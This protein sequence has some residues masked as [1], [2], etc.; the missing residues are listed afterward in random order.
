MYVLIV[1]DDALMG[2]GI[3]AG[4]NALGI[5]AEWV[6]NARDTE[7]AMTTASFDVVVLD[8]G[9]PD[10]DGMQLLRRWRQRGDNLPVLIL[11]ARD[12]VPDRVSGLQ[13]GADDYLSKP[14]DLTELAARLHSLVRRAAG[15]TTQ[16]IQHGDL[17]FNPQTLQVT[18]KDKTLSLSRREI[19]VLDTLLQQPG[20]VVTTAQLQDRLYGWTEGIESNAVAVH[21]HNLR[22]KLGDEWIVTVRGM[23]YRLGAVNESN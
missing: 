5:Q 16:T 4:L 6:R 18:L 23:G 20:R 8:L 7:T 15:R 14:F 9:L 3:Q 19:T 12:A 2:E 13:A 1:E 10:E 11:T 21:I 17:H 22:R